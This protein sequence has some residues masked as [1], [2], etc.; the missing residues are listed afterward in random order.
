MIT[1]HM[2]EDHLGYINKLFSNAGVFD[3]RHAVLLDSG[4]SIHVRQYTPGRMLQP[5]R[6]FSHQG[7]TYGS[8]SL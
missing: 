8:Y 7:A 3:S 6:Q 5:D 2:N 4:Y 1:R